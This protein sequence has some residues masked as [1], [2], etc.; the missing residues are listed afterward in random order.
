MLTLVMLSYIHCIAVSQVPREV[1]MGLA[2]QG[3]MP[4]QN[5]EG[6]NAQSTMMSM[7]IE[8]WLVDEAVPSLQKRTF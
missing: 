2:S 4:F 6:S 8:Y 5:R 3:P 1:L 7:N